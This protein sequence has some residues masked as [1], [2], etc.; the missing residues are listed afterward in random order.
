MS[1]SMPSR[2]LTQL[3][4]MRFRVKTAMQ[5]AQVRAQMAVWGMVGEQNTAA[6]ELSGWLRKCMNMV[7][8]TVW[9]KDI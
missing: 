6:Q 2:D 1:I 4:S 3:L 9:R 7:V 5:R 8:H